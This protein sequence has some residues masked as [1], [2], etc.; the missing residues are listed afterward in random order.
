M[1]VKNVCPCREPAAPTSMEPREHGLERS[2]RGGRVRAQSKYASSSNDCTT[3]P[4]RTAS[5]LKGIAVV[6]TLDPGAGTP[7]ER[8]AHLSK[9]SLM[10]C[11]FSQLPC[12]HTVG[13]NCAPLVVLAGRSRR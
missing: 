1:R 8:R 10:P 5:T 6:R 4:L 12:S 9:E 3:S 7:R 11:V 2:W 13:L